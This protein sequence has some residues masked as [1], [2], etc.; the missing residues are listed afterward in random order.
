MGLA[1]ALPVAEAVM[2]CEA[3]ALVGPKNQANPE[4]GNVR[5]GS[6]PVG[7]VEVFVH[8]RFTAE[9][10]PFRGVIVTG[11]AL[12]SC[13]DGMFWGGLTLIV[14]SGA[15]KDVKLRSL[16]TGH[17]QLTTAVYSCRSKRH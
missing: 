12:T 14:K 2:N 6:E 1:D 9:E 15:V 10:N 5:W 4:R 7:Q 13:P 16:P 8:V 11:I 17:S 3:T